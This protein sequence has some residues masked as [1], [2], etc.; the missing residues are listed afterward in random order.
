MSFSILFPVFEKGNPTKSSAFLPG[1][2]F[3]ALF[4]IKRC[5]IRLAVN[6]RVILQAGNPFIVGI[7]QVPFRKQYL[8]HEKA[9]FEALIQT[10][11][12][13]TGV[14]VSV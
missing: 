4:F 11:R 1:R 7:M 13:K 5:I 9:L 2:P 8:Y 14:K 10:S 12:T 6:L 3:V